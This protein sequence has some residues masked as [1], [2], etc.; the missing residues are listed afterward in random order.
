MSD[1]LSF[2]DTSPRWALPFLFAGQAQKEIFVN[3][4]LSRLDMLLHPLVEG[5]RSNPPASPQEGEAW[6]VDSG[7]SGTWAGHDAEIACR[8]SGNWV[9]AAPQVG[10]TVHDRSTGERWI[11]VEAWEAAP[12]AVTVSGGS[13][14]DVEARAAIGA[15]VAALSHYG[16]MCQS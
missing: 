14:V 13:T 16:L 6:I 11:Y 1:S 4:A 12:A 15:I 2:D 8:Q 3:E 5:R 9:F 10:M 7:A